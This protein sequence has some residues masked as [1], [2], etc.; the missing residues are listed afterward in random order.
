MLEDHKPSP[1][2][3][4]LEYKDEHRRLLS[5]IETFEKNVNRPKPRE[6][7]RLQ[8]LNQPSYEY[9]DLLAKS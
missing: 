1:R 4:R 7:R 5:Y 2:D 8:C 6:L 3:R 9:L